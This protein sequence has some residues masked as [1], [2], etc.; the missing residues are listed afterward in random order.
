MHQSVLI[1]DFRVLLALH[2]MLFVHADK[3]FGECNVYYF[4]TELSGPFFEFFIV[5]IVTLVIVVIVVVVNSSSSSFV[6]LVYFVRVFWGEIIFSCCCYCPNQ[7]FTFIVYRTRWKKYVGLIR[8]V[9]KVICS[10][11]MCI[12]S[13]VCSSLIFEIIESTLHIESAKNVPTQ[14]NAS[15]V[16][17][18]SMRNDVLHQ[19]N[20][21]IGAFVSYAATLILFV[22]DGFFARIRNHFDDF[23]KL[24]ANFMNEIRW[25]HVY[26]LCGAHP[27]H[28]Y[29]VFFRHLYVTISHR[30]FI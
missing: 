30:G 21:F 10:W 3:S 4:R 18:I 29:V 17:F 7:S 25:N 8:I 20:F 14:T 2:F 12:D 5:L 15:R 9:S 16:R 24:C 6:N 28:L 23:N 19:I 1:P 13:F 22:R 11:I 27:S 26:C